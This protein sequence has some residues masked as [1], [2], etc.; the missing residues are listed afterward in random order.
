MTNIAIQVE[1]VSKLYQL[2]TIGTGSLKKDLHRWWTTAVQ[3]KEDPFADDLGAET[4]GVGQS[5]IWALKQINFEVKQG[6]IWGI[7]GGN[8][9]GKS[10]L[11]KIISRIIRPTHGVVRGCGRLSSMLEVGTG[12]HQELSGRENIYLSGFVLGMKRHEIRQ[13]FDEIIEFS[14]I[15]PFIDTPVKRYSSGMY[16]RLAFAV[17][18]H[19]R[20]D[21]LI[22]DEVLSV[23]DA[24]FQKKCLSKMHEFSHNEGRTIL[25][26]SHNLQAV[27][28]LCQQALWL[29]RG[30]AVATGPIQSIIHQYVSQTRSNQFRQTWDQMQ[31]APGSDSVRIKVVEL[32]PQVDTPNAL[33]DVRTPLSIRFQL[34]LL[35][36]NLR[37]LTGIHL[38][39][40]SGECVLDVMSPFTTYQKGVVEGECLIPGNLLNDGSYY[41]SLIVYS[42]KWDALYYH[43]KCLTFDVEDYRSEQ[44]NFS[45]TWMGAVRPALPV[46][47]VQVAGN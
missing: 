41:I 39:S 46:R 9:S 37:M 38:F 15:G 42:D 8:G 3:R 4:N 13:R 40:Y 47:V 34:W 5:H 31:D 44:M 17:A 16:V 18:A 23:G 24:E 27:G 29:Q 43:E 1:D 26:V 36:D 22:V 11:L 20:S 12:F 19:L 35:Q 33:I 32:I 45:G 2:G 28:H 30:N 25:F 21:I 14:G 10:T 6:E 7:I